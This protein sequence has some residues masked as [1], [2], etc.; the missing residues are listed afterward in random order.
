MRIG[1]FLERV[2]REIGGFFTRLRWDAATLRCER[3]I[4]KTG[5]L[6][7]VLLGTVAGPPQALWDKPRLFW[8][9]GRRWEGLG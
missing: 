1:D 6:R 3:P 8:L 2:L 9:G 4:R 7:L 5:T